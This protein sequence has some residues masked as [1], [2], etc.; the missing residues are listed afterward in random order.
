MS[1]ASRDLAI[2]TG[3]ASGMGL[4]TARALRQRGVSI[5]GVDL[6]EQPS[7]LEPDGAVAWVHGDVSQ[8]QTWER[9]Q[10]ACLARDPRGADCL[11]ACAGT[12]VVR[13]FLDTEIEDWQRLFEVNVLGVI[14]GMRAVIPGMVDRGAGA[15]AV[16]CSV[17]SL[18]AEELMSAYS[19]SKAAL[20]HVVRSA[21]LEY[22]AS[23]LRI[24]AVCP[25]II[26]TP[27]L[28]R[29]FESLDD[30]AGARV[31]GARRTPLG[32]LLNPEEVAEALC[33]LVSEGA[34][35]ISGAALTVDGG[36][37]TAY[38]FTGSAGGPAQTPVAG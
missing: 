3:A 35:G 12:I 37:T 19:V 24:N 20:L 26:D 30:P 8:A 15:I 36:L 31:E 14:R 4:A 7:E 6:S 28:R 5:V 38:D 33:F 2:V 27:L 21:A 17:N 23:G 13:P 22:A 29:H 9:V 25:G 11:V 10:E 34:S 18:F 16:I 1:G 32:R